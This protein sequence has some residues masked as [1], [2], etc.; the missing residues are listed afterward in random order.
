MVKE[1]IQ[2]GSL[3]LKNR[4]VMPPIAT[5]LSAEDGSVTDELLA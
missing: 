4:I 1:P 2:I 3:E 5:Y